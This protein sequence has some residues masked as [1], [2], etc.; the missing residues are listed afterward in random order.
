M[1]QII[2][3]E[4]FN[5]DSVSEVKITNDGKYILCGSLDG[6]V[7]IFNSETLE[8]LRTV[9]GSFSEINW[10]EVH[11]KGPVF[12]F[13]CQ[14]ASVWVY[15]AANTD[16]QMSFYGHGESVTCG[17]FTGDGKFLVTGSDD[18]TMKV[19]D[20]KNNELHNTIRGHNFHTTPITS[21]AIAKKKNIIA[22]GSVTNELAITN[23]D[24]GKV[25]KL[26]NP[27][28]KEFSMECIKFFNDDKF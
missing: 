11:P 1:K 2:K 4:K 21:M 9:E 8:L 17:G 25:L 16:L 23:V 19:W 28:E 5:K 3:K 14:D 22:T 12:A 18:M 6:T 24:T 7:N 20:L 26:M 27:G 15:H 13:G 10:L